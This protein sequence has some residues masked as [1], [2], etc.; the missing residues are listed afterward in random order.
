MQYHYETVIYWDQ[1]QN[2][3]IVEAPELPG[4]CAF[5]STRIEAVINAEHAIDIW[6][7]TAK[8]C[9]D[10]VPQPAGPYAFLVHH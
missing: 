2:R 6:I 7:E 10:P 8:I 9:G 1:E 4:C 5:G 3:F